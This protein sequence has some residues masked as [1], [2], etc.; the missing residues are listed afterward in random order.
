[1]TITEINVAGEIVQLKTRVQNPNRVT[2]CKLC[3][4]DICGGDKI[5]RVEHNGRPTW[6][7]LG[8]VANAYTE[9]KSEPK[10]SAP[11]AVE[12]S[13]EQKAAALLELLQ[14]A[15]MTAEERKQ[16]Q[17][18]AGRV[19]ELENNPQQPSGRI[20]ITADGQTFETPEG[21]VMHQ[22]AA[23]IL[24]LIALRE[25]IFLVGPTGTGKTFLCEQIADIIFGDKAEA[26]GL[27]QREEKTSRFG[28]I[29]MTE[30]TSEA[31]LFGR[32]VPRGESGSFEYLTSEF[33]DKYENGGLFLIDEFDAGN[34]NVILK[35]NAA[36]SNGIASVPNRAEN[37]YAR[38]HP[39]FIC[40]ASANTFG[41]GADFQY[42]GRECLDMS[43]LNRFQMGT[44]IVDYDEALEAKLCPNKETYNALVKLR[45]L[46]E[47]NGIEQV[48]STR[49][50]RKAN[51]MVQA[52][53]DTA[54]ILGRI[55][56][57]WSA[58][59]RSQAEAAGIV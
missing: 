9:G 32:L 16:L 4:N 14:S 33:I 5:A 30:G 22:A 27:T 54:K 6:S 49:T 23:M 29:S 51:R 13:A 20:E 56:T 35:L 19:N 45:Q 1:M 47:T 59:E 12:K 2:R 41:R 58:D 3:G 31:E 28:F 21:E 11:T 37:P 18:L 40:I 24:E 43:T 55:L 36:L 38:R 48:V 17:E 46:V 8:C 50:F 53:W 26:F 10:P 42:T 39:E 44:V 7:H 15:G 57:G 52:G 25:E 34:A